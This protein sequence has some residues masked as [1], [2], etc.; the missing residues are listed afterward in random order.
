MSRGGRSSPAIRRSVAGLVGGAAPST[1]APGARRS[2]R[3]AP[4]HLAAVLAAQ[5]RLQLLRRDDAVAVGVQLGEGAA[6]QAVPVVAGLQLRVARGEGLERM[7]GAR[8][9]VPSPGLQPTSS[10]PAGRHLLHQPPTA[11]HPATLPAWRTTLQSAMAA[12]HSSHAP[13][14]AQQHTSQPP[15][16]TPALTTRQSAM[17]ATHSSQAMVPSGATDTWPSSCSTSPGDSL[18]RPGS[19]SA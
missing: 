16:C 2:T 18:K 7:L 17:A 14:H 15:P 10:Q 3:R 4:P 12:T 19:S 11:R 8:R 9:Q 6:H 13:R 5:Q 1:P